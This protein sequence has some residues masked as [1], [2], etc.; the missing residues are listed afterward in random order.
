MAGLA[1]DKRLFQTFDYHHKVGSTL[2]LFLSENCPLRHDVTKRQAIHINPGLDRVS[3]SL[4][5]KNSYMRTVKH[6]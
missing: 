5:I 6:I 2:Q 4:A 3:V 1:S